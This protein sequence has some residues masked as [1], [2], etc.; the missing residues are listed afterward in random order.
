MKRINKKKG[1]IKDFLLENHELIDNSDLIYW[2]QE[3]GRPLRWLV[4]NADS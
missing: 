2:K 3:T 4:R 1:A